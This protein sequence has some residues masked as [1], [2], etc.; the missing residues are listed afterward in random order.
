MAFSESGFSAER[1]DGNTYPSASDAP[2]MPRKAARACGESGTSWGRLI[3]IR[4]GGMHHL[5]FGKLISDRRMRLVSPGRAI[6][7]A[8]NW[9]A[10]RTVGQ[11]SYSSMEVINAPSSRSP[12]MAGR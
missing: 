9:S 3:F 11:P 6:V 4:S 10:A 7:N 5:A 2:Q 12:V 8:R 1:M